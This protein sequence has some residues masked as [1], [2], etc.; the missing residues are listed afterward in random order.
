MERFETKA[1]ETR[2]RE[3][4]I[5]DYIRRRVDRIM[6]DAGDDISCVSSD[7]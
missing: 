4:D 5:A 7:E 1:L 2:S 6:F 3:K